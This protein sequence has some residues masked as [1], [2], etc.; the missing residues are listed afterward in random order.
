MDCSIFECTLRY[1]WTINQPWNAHGMTYNGWVR[2]YTAVDKVATSGYYCTGWVS[3]AIVWLLSIDYRVS[4]HWCGHGQP[5]IIQ[6][7][8]STYR[9][10]MNS[11]LRSRSL[12]KSTTIS[13]DSLW[14]PSV[15]GIYIYTYINICKAREW[16]HWFRKRVMINAGSSDLI[17][18]SQ[19]SLTHA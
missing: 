6:T 4:C 18:T 10:F 19:Y 1:S 17:D 7:L 14:W 5:R 9:R 15:L 12:L 13:I 2:H 3:V 8:M 16:V 11:I